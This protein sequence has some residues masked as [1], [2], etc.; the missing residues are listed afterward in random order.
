M[1]AGHYCSEFKKA[2]VASMVNVS[3]NGDYD[4]WY[5]IKRVDGKTITLFKGFSGG[6]TFTKQIRKDKNG[7]EYFTVEHKGFYSM[8]LGRTE[9]IKCVPFKDESGSYKNHKRD[10]EK[11]EL[12][13]QESSELKP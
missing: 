11:E 6:E 8:F 7:R 3:M 1:I 10:D 9:K 5:P 2:N 12:L 13:A 4:F